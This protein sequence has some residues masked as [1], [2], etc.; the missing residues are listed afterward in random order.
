MPRRSALTPAQCKIWKQYPYINPL[1]NKSINPFSKAGLYKQFMREC[2]ADPIAQI[3]VT[4]NAAVSPKRVQLVNMATSPIRPITHSMGTRTEAGHSVN[5]STSPMV[6]RMKNAAVSPKKASMHSM[7][8]S[9]NVPIVYNASA[10]TYSTSH[11]R[12]L[13][14][15]NAVANNENINNIFLPLPPTKNL[16]KI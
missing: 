6:T 9:T 8:T 5:T 16:K 13:G 14:N 7:G 3:V 2:N 1:T 15:V 10:S 4:Q 12:N 11:I